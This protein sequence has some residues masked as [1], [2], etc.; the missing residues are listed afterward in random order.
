MQ[1]ISW[2]LA[3]RQVYHETQLICLSWF[4]YTREAVDMR[5]KRHPL[6]FFSFS[7]FSFLSKWWTKHSVIH[8][9]E[10]VSYWTISEQLSVY[11]VKVNDTE[12]IWYPRFSLFNRGN[13]SREQKCA[14]NIPK[15]KK[16]EAGLSFHENRMILPSYSCFVALNVQYVWIPWIA[17]AEDIWLRRGRYSFAISDQILDKE[18]S[19]TVWR[20]NLIEVTWHIVSYCKL[21]ALAVT[22]NSMVNVPHKLKIWKLSSKQYSWLI[23]MIGKSNIYCS[24]STLV[25]QNFRYAL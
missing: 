11:G 10:T 21:L 16:T 9:K 12:K 25:L 1:S 13:Y 15:E 23:V 8:N 14:C 17:S 7:F 4:E 6:F 3:A 18:L 22:N 5:I 24:A 19:C 20:P 2:V